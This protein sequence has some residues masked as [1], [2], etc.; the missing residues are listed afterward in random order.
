MSTLAWA[1]GS[2]RH[3]ELECMEDKTKYSSSGVF[4]SCI[5][6]T[7]HTWAL[8]IKG[9]LFVPMLK[10]LSI[11]IAVAMGMI[12]LRDSLYIGSSF[13]SIF[14]I[15]YCRS[16][17]DR[18]KCNNDPVLQVMWGKAKELAMVATSRIPT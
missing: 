5:N 9:P 7:I 6:N 8:R 11:V 4:G 16:Q 10:P 3:I 1:S 15:E 14:V 12:F 13:V 2:R 18:G 17:L